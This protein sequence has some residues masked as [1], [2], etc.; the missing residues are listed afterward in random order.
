MLAAAPVIGFL[1][2]TDFALAETFFCGTL[3]L[4]V[5]SRDSFALVLSAAGGVTIRCVK[6]AADFAPQ[7]FTILGWE[8]PDLSTAAASAIAAGVEPLRFSWFQQDSQGI[9][10]APGGD[11]VFWFK[12]PFGNTLS[13]SH[14]GAEP[15][16]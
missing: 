11:Q 6:V 14:H 12:D 15:A 16:A 13:F 10:T 1:P 5:L 3:G 9:W 4:P 8:V 2:V 7:P